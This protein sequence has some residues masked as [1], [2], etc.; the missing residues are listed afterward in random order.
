MSKFCAAAV[1]YST[2]ECNGLL[3]VIEASLHKEYVCELA[4]GKKDGRA[5]HFSRYLNPCNL[6]FV[7]GKM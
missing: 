4:F 3:G 6:Q 1:M 2:T 5:S 7:E